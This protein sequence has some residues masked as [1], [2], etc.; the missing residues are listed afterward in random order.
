[1]SLDESA[2]PRPSEASPDAGLCER[3]FVVLNAIFLKKMATTADIAGLSGIDEQTLSPILEQAAS[4]ELILT[5]DSGHLLLASGSQAV[6]RHYDEKYVELRNDPALLGWYD[7]F[8]TLN[9][10]FIAALTNWQ[11]LHGDDLLFKALDIVEQLC[12]TLAELLPQIPR[13]AGYQRRFEKALG[14]IEAGDADLLCN[15]RRD[16]AH[17]IWFEFHED[18]L[19]VLGRPRDTT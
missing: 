4:A 3:D 15:P 16:S 13:Y 1:M 11:Q 10:R 2:A 12:T 14:A 9:R 7:G 5:T 8:E 17:N 18:I 19:C 6:Q